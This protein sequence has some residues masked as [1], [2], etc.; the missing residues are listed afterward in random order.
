MVR[1]GRLGADS[2]VARPI[3]PRASTPSLAR[4][5][6]RP[7]TS[8]GADVPERRIGP[9][10]D[11]DGSW[12]TTRGRVTMPGPKIGTVRLSV[13]RSRYSPRPRAPRG[14]LRPRERFSRVSSER[15]PRMAKNRCP[16]RH[17]DHIRPPELLAR[18]PARLRGR[19]TVKQSC[20]PT[21]ANCAD[22]LSW[23]YP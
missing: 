2:E 15:C 9:N 4:T 17:R 7:R 18:P 8:Y 21:C 5:P 22:P 1:L 20:E 11:A 16:E 13:L 6:Y 12:G 3:W 14:R 23:C 10:G 19:S